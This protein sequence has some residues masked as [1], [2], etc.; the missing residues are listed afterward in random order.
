MEKLT[1]IYR[2][3]RQSFNVMVSQPTTE[4]D[5]WNDRRWPGFLSG[6]IFRESRHLG[7][8]QKNQPV[9]KKAPLL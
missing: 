4:W 1:N 9:N 5:A 7:D 2:S 6:Q 8:L 3:A